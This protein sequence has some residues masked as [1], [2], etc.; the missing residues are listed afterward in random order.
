MLHKCPDTQKRLGLEVE[1]KI[2][3]SLGAQGVCWRGAG[4]MDLIPEHLQGSIHQS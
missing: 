3:P 2:I 4:Q 1:T